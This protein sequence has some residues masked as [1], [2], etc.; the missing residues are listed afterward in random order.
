MN[1]NLLREGETMF[2]GSNL[3]L[4]NLDEIHLITEALIYYVKQLSAYGHSL[5]ELYPEADANN[6]YKQLGILAE[7]AKGGEE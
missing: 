6:L 1:T 2:N 7:L 4:S 3:G 5:K